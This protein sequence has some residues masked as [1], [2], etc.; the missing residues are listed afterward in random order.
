MFTCFTAV[1][2]PGV[3]L[4][5]ETITSGFDLAYLPEPIYP[6][7]PPSG[8]QLGSFNYNAVLRDDHNTSPAFAFSWT[9]Q[10]W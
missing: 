6:I 2:V 9:C 3:V 8:T 7:Q 4:R 1:P 10:V 5:P